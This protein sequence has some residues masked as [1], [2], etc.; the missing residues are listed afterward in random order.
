MDRLLYLI[1]VLLLILGLIHK[2]MLIMKILI[3]LRIELW[4]P[5]WNQLEK[6]AAVQALMMKTLISKRSNKRKNSGNRRVWQR[7]LIWRIGWVILLRK[8]E[9]SIM[10]LKA[11]YLIT[12]WKNR[13]KINMTTKVHQIVVIVYLR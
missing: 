8:K 10:K 3:R 1:K 9:V 13:N 12:K 2:L 5:S 6:T 4:V 7:S 11:K